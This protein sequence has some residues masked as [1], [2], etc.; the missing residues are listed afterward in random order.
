M[1]EA[2]RELRSRKRAGLVLHAMLGEPGRAW[3]GDE[4]ARIAGVSPYTVHQVLARLEDQ[5]WVTRRG[6]GP[7]MTRKLTRPGQLLDAWARE[8][9]LSAYKVR[10]FRRL[11]PDPAAQ[12]AA[13]VGFL[14]H[15]NLDWALTLEHGAERLAPSLTGLPGAMTMLV[16][17]DLPWER[18]GRAAGFRPVE[19]GENFVF[20]STPH[21]GPRM[22][23]QRALLARKTAEL[24]ALELVV[25]DQS[26]EEVEKQLQTRADLHEAV[27]MLQAEID[28]L[29]V[30][31]KATR[32]RSTVRVAIFA[33]YSSDLQSDQS[34]DAQLHECREH[35]PAHEHL[36]KGAAVDTGIA[37]QT[38]QDLDQHAAER[39][40]SSWRSSMALTTQSSGAFRATRVGGGEC[41]ARG[42]RIR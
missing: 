42:Q 6:K 32:R 18:L 28:E 35:A 16:P 2:A 9:T 38:L 1:A 15:L 40:G 17:E 7:A 12:E 23:R 21:P 11:A 10:R 37:R 27:T 24:G 33:R 26:Q 22:G 20:L 39:D 30:R 31:R 8:H 13:L 4:L 41:S 25:E 5:L 3:K 14:E 36:V 19:E 34:L 29:K